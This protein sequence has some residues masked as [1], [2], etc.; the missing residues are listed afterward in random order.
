MLC[1]VGKLPANIASYISFL[2][3]PFLL[4]R[5][6]FD[7]LFISKDL[8]LFYGCELFCLDT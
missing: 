5:T 7:H 2:H 4:S 8:S 3:F 1:L 6:P